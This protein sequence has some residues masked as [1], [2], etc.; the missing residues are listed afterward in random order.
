MLW[1]LLLG[2]IGDSCSRE[3]YLALTLAPN[4][5]R[6]VGRIAMPLAL[7]PTA[8]ISRGDFEEA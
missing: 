4:K 6:R 5:T 7:L 2:S 3:P 1:Y 8:K